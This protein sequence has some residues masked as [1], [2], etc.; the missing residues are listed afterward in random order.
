MNF[1]NYYKI[2]IS[3]F[4]FWLWL[5]I[6]SIFTIASMGALF[7]FL[8]VPIIVF[9]QLK[10]TD[11]SYNDKELKISKGLV[12]KTK[13]TIAINEIEEINVK[14]GLLNLIAKARPISLAHIKNLNE[15]ADKFIQVWN[16]NR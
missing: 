16:N 12:F 14:L 10:N 11:Y 5:I 8:I 1:N 15:E 7:F 9:F 2:P 3:M 4:W 6:M 13:S